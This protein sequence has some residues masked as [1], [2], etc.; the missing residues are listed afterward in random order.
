MTEMQDEGRTTGNLPV[1][2]HL[3]PTG[4][5]RGHALFFDRDE[6]GCFVLEIVPLAA[7]S[8]LE[9]AGEA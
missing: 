6:N 5:E 8:R 1:R 9:V 7:A 3:R 2:R 4:N